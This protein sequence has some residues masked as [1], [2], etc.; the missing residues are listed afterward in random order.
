MDV[1]N[2]EEEAVKTSRVDKLGNT[3]VSAPSSP[4]KQ[5]KL[6][7][8]I[9]E[10]PP[11]TTINDLPNEVL[12]R[13]FS[14]LQV[15]ELNQ[16]RVVC[17]RWNFVMNDKHTWNQS[18]KSKFNTPR[19]FP[20]VTN[21]YNWM[22]EY[23]TRTDAIRK[24][25][26][27]TSFHNRYSLSYSE[28]PMM[29]TQQ[30]SDFNANSRLGKLIS[31]DQRSGE[32]RIHGLKDTRNLSYLPSPSMNYNFDQV[33]VLLTQ[34]YLLVGKR[35][36]CLDIRSLPTMSSQ[37]SAYSYKTIDT[38]D[39]SP[40]PLEQVQ[41]EGTDNNEEVQVEIQ[42]SSQVPVLSIA[43]NPEASQKYKRG[44]I[45]TG[46]AT[47]SL[48]T[49]SLLGQLIKRVRIQSEVILNIASDFKKFI[50]V[51]TETNVYIIDYLE[52]TILKKIPLGFTIWN[53]Y[54]GPRNIEYYLRFRDCKNQLDVDFADFNIIINY[55]RYIKVYNFKD[56]NNIL[57]KDLTLPDHITITISKM[58]D[59][60]LSRQKR[61]RNKNIIGKDG[62]LFANLLSDDRIIIWNVRNEYDDET[63]IIPITTLRPKMTYDKYYPGLEDFIE[64]NELQ[65]ITAIT[66]NSLFIAVGGYKGVC[67]LYDNFTGACLRVISLKNPKHF[68]LYAPNVVIP[69]SFIHLNPD[70]R[71]CN[72]VISSSIGYCQYFQF[73]DLT[74]DVNDGKKSNN[75][76]FSKNNNRLSAT[77]IKRQIHYAVEDFER[78]I[79]DERLREEL[80]L[81]FNGDDETRLKNFL[82]E[83]GGEEGVD[84]ELALAIAL[85][86]S[87][88]QHQLD[89]QY[90]RDISQVSSLGEVDGEEE[91]DEELQLALELS[92]IMHEEET[93]GYGEV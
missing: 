65:S 63:G 13:V 6:S 17:K 82:N 66:I 9:V 33:C 48:K 87:Q 59:L 37:Q 20:S 57:M 52:L 12:V 19:V 70:V 27:G 11:K 75:G 85:S 67:K 84:E 73:G 21:S 45:I 18:F 15:T 41:G 77:K 44:D 51:N 68:S 4:I 29:I 93:N 3:I 55:K 74:T 91:N 28:A 86:Q 78:D 61:A 83:E 24:W 26:R 1:A 25:K 47:G 49:W 43:F 23:V 71:D 90:S 16:L 60:T 79:E 50:I 36:G 32:V 53:E 35:N 22:H 72:G 7:S 89:Q 54:Q 92:R 88:H 56:L 58:Q 30:I 46:S 5:R 80:A 76:S 62:L 14:N 2:H 34:K 69:T 64:E 31:Y 8:S 38:N 10:P 42:N 81:K 39:G 40:P